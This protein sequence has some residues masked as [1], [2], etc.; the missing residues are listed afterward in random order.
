[1]IGKPDVPIPTD[2]TVLIVPSAFL[3]QFGAHRSS[4]EVLAG[5]AGLGFRDVRVTE[6]WECALREAVMEYTCEETPSRPVISP[7][8]SAVV[9]LI[10]MRF[11]SLMGNL[12]PF[13]SPVEAMCEEFSGHPIVLLVACPSQST[14]IVSNSLATDIRIVVPASLR[15]ALLPLVTRADNFTAGVSNENYI[16][17]AC[18]DESILR[19]SG[20]D[21]VMAVL[22]KAE[23]GALCD[24]D[25]MEPYACSEGCFGSPFFSEDCFVARHR[26][27]ELV[28]SFDTTAKAVRRRVPHVVRAG[29]RLDENMSRA[30]TKLSKIDELAESLPGRDCGMCGAPTCNAFAEDVVL[31]R[32]TECACVHLN[33]Y[34]GG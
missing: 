6:D 4:H 25:L 3:V 18:R 30:I 12:A 2:D 9:N 34:E 29:L 19:V 27:L 22:E 23:D 1:M 32:A 5:L 15:S 7:V 31:G 10:E 21:H 26:R 16:E 8:C 11:P 20:I 24:I 28:G 14:S 17:G 33:G 13:L